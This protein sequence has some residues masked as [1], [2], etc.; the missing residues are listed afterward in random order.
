MR[1]ISINTTQNVAIDYELAGLMERLLAFLLDTVILVAY[2]YVIGWTLALGN[3]FRDSNDIVL[4]IVIVF[5]IFPPVIGYHLICEAFWNGQ[6]IGKKALGIKVMK[7]NGQQMDIGDYGKRWMFRLVDILFSCGSVAVITIM[8]NDY[9]QRLGDIVGDTC[10]VKTNPRNQMSIVDVLKIK[11]QENYEPKYEGVVR[12]TEEDML[13]LK[14]TLDRAKTNPNKHY[15]KLLALLTEK[16]CKE[17]DIKKVPKKRTKFLKTI[18][19]DYIVL[20]R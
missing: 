3:T 2:I 10:V 5:I 13:L 8:S 16:I 4:F 14:N 11:T 7:C 9:N 15:K 18:L 17:L 1:T 6:S 12:F 20:T 19:N